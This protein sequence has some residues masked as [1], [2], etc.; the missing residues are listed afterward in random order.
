MQK[1]KDIIFAVAVAA[2][3]LII[4]IHFNQLLNWGS[5]LLSLMLP[6]FFGLIIA[7]ILNV[8]M[9]AISKQLEKISIFKKEK[10]RNG[11]SLILTIILLVAILAF[12]IS[13]VIPYFVESV[14]SLLN[15]MD[16]DANNL[17]NWIQ[18]MQIQFEP[19]KEYIAKIEWSN[20]L[21]QLSDMMGDIFKTLLQSIPQIG[22]SLFGLFISVIIAIYV[23]LDKKRL[24]R[25]VQNILHAYFKPKYVE[26]I[27]HVA[28]LFANTYSNFLTG[29]CVEAVILGSLMAIVLSLLKIPYAGIIAVMA[30]IFQ[31]IPYIGSLSAWIIGGLLILLTAPSQVILYLV[32][33]QVVQFFEGQFIYPRVVGGSVG[34]P[35]LFTLVA[36]FIGGKLFGLLGMLF[37]IPLTSV[38]YQLIGEDVRTRLGR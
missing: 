30:A 12:I 23:L 33:Y 16:A 13:S 24:T 7:F 15:G 22:S 2:I 5:G 34:L 37:F 25:Q 36:V 20:V 14:L 10:L 18:S 35:A 3:G 1:R 27:E 17:L 6:I 19:L 28:M 32:V 31:F 8:P 29:Q 21:K 11:M 4:A 26:K 9:T 38:I